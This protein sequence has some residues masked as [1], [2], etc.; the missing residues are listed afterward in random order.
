MTPAGL[1]GKGDNEAALELAG[2]SLADVVRTSSYGVNLEQ[3][4]DVGR[5]H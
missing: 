1:I 4:R 3:W 5:S 2:A